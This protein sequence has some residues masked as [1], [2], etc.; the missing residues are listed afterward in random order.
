MLVLFILLLLVGIV[1]IFQF[2]L[3][4]FKEKVEIDVENRMEKFKQEAKKQA[5]QGVLDINLIDYPEKIYYKNLYFLGIP[6]FTVKK[7]VIFE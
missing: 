6:F 1:Y 4:G 5:E 3:E 7:K 2:N